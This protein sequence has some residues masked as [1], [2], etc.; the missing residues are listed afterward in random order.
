L[1]ETIL[2]GQNMRIDVYLNLSIISTSHAY[3]RHQSPF[4]EHSF[5]RITTFIHQQNA[6]DDAAATSRSH[7]NQF[8]VPPFG[9]NKHNIGNTS[10][11]S[12]STI[13]T[14]HHLMNTNNNTNKSFNTTAK[15]EQ[16]SRTYMRP[17]KNRV[18][19]KHFHEV[20]H[21]NQILFLVSF[22]SSFR[23]RIPSSLSCSNQQQPIEMPINIP[24]EQ[25]LYDRKVE[26]DR[27]N[28]LCQKYNI[29]PLFQ[30]NWL[31]QLRYVPQERPDFGQIKQSQQ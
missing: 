12:S 15:Y 14:C 17:P 10:S 23:S 28:D 31:R 6:L 16:R 21:R 4:V 1:L 25:S 7:K 11:T 20:F 5:R 18:D 27:E 26:M 3:E 2:E 30:R 24:C 19:S 8:D 9:D 29:P 22:D 13:K